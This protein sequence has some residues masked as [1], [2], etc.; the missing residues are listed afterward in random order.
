MKCCGH[1][2]LCPGCTAARE[3]VVGWYHTGPRLRQSD[4]DITDLMA[5]YCETPLLV[6]CEVQV[7]LLAQLCRSYQT[8]STLLFPD[9]VDRL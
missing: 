3:R 8:C 1:R 2:R 6:I 9:V 5:S 4:L 7:L